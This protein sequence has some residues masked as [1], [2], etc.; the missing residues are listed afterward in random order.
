MPIFETVVVVLLVLILLKSY[1][2]NLSIEKKQKEEAV[3]F[4]P[5]PMS[6]GG[7]YFEFPKDYDLRGLFNVPRPP[8][9]EVK[10]V[11][12]KEES[13]TGYV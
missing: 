4:H 6:P 2:W 12:K 3:F 11:P 10:D 13:P 5:N 7:G 8:P 9:S 1:G